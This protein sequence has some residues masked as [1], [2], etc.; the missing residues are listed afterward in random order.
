M[1]IKKI[2]ILYISRTSKFTG[3]ENILLDIVKYIDKKSFHPIV[4]LPDSKGLF[5]EKLIQSGI[6]TIIVRMPFLRVTYNPFI[7][8]WFAINVVI[9][10]IVFFFTVVRLKVDIVTCHTIQ[11]AFYL[12][13]PAKLLSKKLIICFKNILDKKWKKYIRAKFTGLF[14]DKIIAVSKKAL[15]DFTNFNSERVNR[16]KA[17]VIYDCLNYKEYVKNIYHEPI[18]KFFKKKNGDFIIVNIGSL[19]ELKG[20]TLLV[21]S[22]SRKKLKDK[23]IRVILIG[24]IYDSKDLIYRKKIV[25][26]IKA[27]DLEDKVFLAGYQ[28]NVKGILKSTD[29]VVHCPIIDD[30]LP[31]VVLEG[32]ALRNIVIAT[33][34]G[35]I[36]EM[37]TDS[38]NGFLIEVNSDALADKI[39]YVYKNRY[40][41]EKIKENALKTLI[42]KFSLK[43]QIND[44]EILYKRI[45]NK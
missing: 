39:Y 42:N 1:L 35:G 31:R 44:L 24:G 43:K 33:K 3:A 40:N 32:Y 28:K 13:L 36:P 21:K 22:I 14:A 11:E 41:L 19:T 18:D 8:L 5:Y 45:I 17:E 34:V 2:K 7:L 25:E 4:V 23:K 12:F 10:N 9:I 16:A 30:A 38:Y 20:Q 26:M 29:A 6:D 15:E 27:N 37:I